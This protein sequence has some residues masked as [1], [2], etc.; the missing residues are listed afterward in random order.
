MKR[1]NEIERPEQKSCG[2]ANSAWL[3]GSG[4]RARA[5]VAGRFAL[6]AAISIVGFATTSRGAP[7]P[8][9]IPANRLWSSFDISYVVRVAPASGG[10]IVQV[11][12]PLPS[13]DDYQTISHL[14]IDAPVGARM[15]K[16]KDGD[17]SAN[18]TVDASNMHAP[19]QIR[20]SF[21]VVRFEHHIDWA[22]AID[23]PGAFP[24]GVAPFLDPGKAASG[25]VAIA[26][27]SREETQGIDSPVDKAR[28][29]YNY[30]VSTI[31]GDHDAAGACSAAA[32]GAVGS[33]NGGRAD[34]DT[35]F[36]EMAR[37]VGIPARLQV[38]FSLPTGQ[39]KG[40]VAGDHGWAEFYANGIGWIPVDLSEA[41]KD[42]RNRDGFF[43]AIDARRV[44][45]S[46]GQG[47]TDAS[48]RGSV[49]A[50]SA[51][52]P[53]IEVDG[54]PC[55]HYSLDLFFDQ[56]KIASSRFVVVRKAIYAGGSWMTGSS[57]S[58][59]SS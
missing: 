28:K 17:Q 34:F 48:G 24:K 51:A 19:I 12:I 27:I 39:Q 36:V 55:A 37:A 38:G 2:R 16:E 15:R 58:R 1:Q 26:A 20:V 50:N 29:I 40:I 43:G 13:S 14:Q 44:V 6:A 9:P 59:L 3:R 56:V 21:H 41:A 49:A 52:Y 31:C 5:R 23:P 25:G 22:T 18:L 54:K 10:R 47:M 45:I 57:P 8:A 30:V 4:P 11:S 53:S 46:T 35:L 7:P 32:P 33:E 42:P